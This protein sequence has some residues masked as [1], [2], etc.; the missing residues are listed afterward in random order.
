M[1]FIEHFIDHLSLKTFILEK[2][3]AVL[4]KSVAVF[5][6]HVSS[7][8]YPSHKFSLCFDHEIGNV[9]NFKL[10]YCIKLQMIYNKASSESEYLFI[11][12]YYYYS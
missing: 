6:M 7:D 3:P 8:F 11:L 5:T 4:Q 12:H 10:I 1:C 2:Y 9:V